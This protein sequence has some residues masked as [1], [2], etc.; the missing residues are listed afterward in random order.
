M[1]QSNVERIIGVLVTDEGVPPPVRPGPAGHAR[2]AE[3][4]IGVE[5]TR[6]ERHA[7]E[8]LNPK[9]WRASPTHSTRGCRSRT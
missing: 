5:L 4:E 9:T 7:L 2:G 6:C 3:A 1:S 8:N